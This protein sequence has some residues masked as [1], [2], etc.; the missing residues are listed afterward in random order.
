MTHKMTFD[1]TRQH[2]SK[3]T[4]AM[5]ASISKSVTTQYEIEDINTVAPYLIAP[6]AWTWTPATFNGSRSNANWEQQSVFALDFDNGFTPEQALEITDRYNIVPNIIYSSFSDSPELRKFRILFFLDR[7]I[8]NKD[9]AKFIQTNLMNMFEGN[10]D[11][12]CKDYARMFYGGKELLFLN[13]V[14]VSSEHLMDVLNTIQVANDSMKTRKVFDFGAKGV[15]SY[16]YKDNTPSQTDSTGLYNGGKTIENF[17]FDKA[18]MEVKIFDDFLNHNW[19]THT[20]LFGLATNL[21]WIKGGLKLMKDTMEEAVRNGKAGYTENN[22]GIFPY[23]SKMQYTPQRLEN[24]SPYEE[25]RE[26]GKNIINAVRL[27][28]GEVVVLEQKTTMTL[29]DAQAKFNE[30]FQK[31]LDAESGV[32]LFKVPT[33]FGKTAALESVEGVTIALPTHKLKDEVSGRMKVEHK[34]T[35]NLPEFSEEV[36]HR[37]EFLYELGL[38][39]KASSLLIEIANSTEKEGK[40]IMSDIFYAN[41]FVKANRECYKATQTVLTTHQKASFCTFASD[42]L[43]FDEDPLQCF[44]QVKEMKIG[45]LNNLLNLKEIKPIVEVVKSFLEKLDASTIETMK[46]FVFDY[47]KLVDVL[48]EAEVDSTIL[49]LLNCEYLF[50]DLER[51][52]E[53]HYVVKR[54]IPKTKKTIIMSATASD[55]I[56]KKLFG[57]DLVIV[58][59]MNIEQ[60]GQVVQ[61]T[62]YSLSK[63]SLNEQHSKITPLVGQLP[64]ITFKD[65]KHYF[66]NSV[67]DMHFGNCSGYDLYKGEDI[68][69]VGTPHKNNYLYFLYANALGVKVRTRDNQIQNQTITRNGVSF[70]FNTFLNEDLREIQLSLI[71]ADLVQA[72][73]RNRS[74]REDCT[75]YVYSNLP[76]RQTTKFTR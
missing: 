49:D 41:E 45:D 54:E 70:K 27:S 43:I 21:Y 39:T 33:G 52:N 36:K 44:L 14:E 63:T 3:P 24:F 8:T 23:V 6:V 17:N 47:D 59:L 20:E 75:A 74:L 18:R 31:A 71:E 38:Y 58:D 37:L 66:K 42:T 25:D 46:Q 29:S 55:F 5:I 1:C 67:R 53:I 2:S 9:E 10:A 56:Y 62:K 19:L 69:V 65:T 68:A 32:Y 30:E 15:S 34:V 76:L 72:V 13:N 60:V 26:E 16:Y 11:K 4:Q 22:F 73:G 35:P 61:N 28:K 40:Y 57:N 7:S 48:S 50:K 12:A 64:V 51:Q